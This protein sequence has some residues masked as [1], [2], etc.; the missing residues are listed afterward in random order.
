MN[1]SIISTIDELNNFIENN[2]KCVI[3]YFSPVCVNCKLVEYYLYN[4]SKEYPNVKFI[5]CN[6]DAI[7]SVR[8]KLNIN[9]LPSV[10][11][12]KK[13]EIVCR[14]VGTVE[15]TLKFGIENYLL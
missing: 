4:F 6:I 9:V 5:K 8:E 10:F 1:L 14:Y 12:Y 13:G 7:P 2:E 11:Y 15:K 3:S